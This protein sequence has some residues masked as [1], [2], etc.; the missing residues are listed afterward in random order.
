MGRRHSRAG[1]DPGQFPL[2]RSGLGAA[3]PGL[4]RYSCST[5][6][7][8]TSASRSA[9]SSRAPLSRRL[10]ILIIFAAMDLISEVLEPWVRLRRGGERPDPALVAL[11]VQCDRHRGR[12]RQRRARTPLR[13][14]AQGRAAA[15]SREAAGARRDRRLGL[16]LIDSH[17]SSASSPALL[18]SEREKGACPAR[19]PS[20]VGRAGNPRSVDEASG[21]AGPALGA[22]I[23]RLNSN[24]ILTIRLEHDDGARTATR[25]RPRR[26]GSTTRR[27]TSVPP[28]SGT[29]L[30][31]RS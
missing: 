19:E 29:T 2:L 13:P 17:G 26:G 6:W 3:A 20:P 4:L 7:P 9:G 21:I 18:P 14:E 8:R 30:T 31:P 15:A 16:P 1:H 10:A 23:C 25:T 28:A 5:G 24:P 11:P 22:I 27:S 12:D